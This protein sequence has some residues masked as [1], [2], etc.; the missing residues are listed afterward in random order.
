[1]CYRRDFRLQPLSHALFNVVVVD[2][3]CTSLFLLGFH[4]IFG[5]LLYKTGRLARKAGRTTQ[6]VISEKIVLYLQREMC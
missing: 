1:M 6:A 4:N 3:S 5:V 2:F